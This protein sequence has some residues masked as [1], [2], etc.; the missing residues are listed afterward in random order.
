MLTS[1][2]LYVMQ[3]HPYNYGSPESNAHVTLFL[4]F[5]RITNDFR[6]L[7]IGFKL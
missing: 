5:E 1:F 4:T 6:L 3:I 2:F 7:K